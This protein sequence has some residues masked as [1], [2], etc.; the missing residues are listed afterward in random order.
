[1]DRYIKCKNMLKH[2]VDKIAFMKRWRIMTER[3]MIRNWQVEIQ[4]E[5]TMSEMKNYFSGLI[6]RL[7]I[8]KERL[9]ESKVNSN[10]QN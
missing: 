6:S 3:I 5:N 10:Y 2:L 9:R 4:G 8:A 7:N 1:M